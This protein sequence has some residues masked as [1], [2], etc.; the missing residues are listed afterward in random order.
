[1]S[2]LAGTIASSTELSTNSAL[3]RP[4]VSPSLSVIVAASLWLCVGETVKY[5]SRAARGSSTEAVV[6]PTLVRAVSGNFY[7]VAL[8]LRQSHRRT[9]SK[10]IISGA[11]NGHPPLPGPWKEVIHK[12]TGKLYYH[13]TLTDETTYD[14]PKEPTDEVEVCCIFIYTQRICY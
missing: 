1:M 14:K 11:M 7:E 5:T 9:T 13:N 6:W 4:L 12:D 2:E 10:T 3:P 8:P